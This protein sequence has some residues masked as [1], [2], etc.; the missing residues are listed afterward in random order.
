MAV[1]YDG[2]RS[3]PWFDPDADLAFCKALEAGADPTKV[4]VRK[5]DL[6][7]NDPNFADKV[8]SAFREQWD[9]GQRKPST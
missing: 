3:K 9:S 8:A 2:K 6:H 5:L 4:E 7:I 1:D